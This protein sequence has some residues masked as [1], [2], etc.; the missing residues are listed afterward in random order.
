M[1]S[2]FR[3]FRLNIEESESAR[4]E[5]ETRTRH[6]FYMPFSIIYIY[7]LLLFVATYDFS[8]FGSR[9][10]R[11]QLNYYYIYCFTEKLK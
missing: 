7:N 11:N 1:K 8:S 4:R 10:I 9:T 6:I 3:L 2:V 5:Q